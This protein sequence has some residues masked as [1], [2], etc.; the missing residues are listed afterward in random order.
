MHDDCVCALALAWR[1]F[2]NKQVAY[3]TDLSWINDD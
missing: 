2:D 3:D 1:C